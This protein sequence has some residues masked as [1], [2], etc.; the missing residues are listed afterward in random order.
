VS[1]KK[2]PRSAKSTHAKQPKR[3][4]LDARLTIVQAADLHRALSARLA[5]GR[6][7]V[8]DGTRVEEIDTAILQLLTSLW[9]TSQERGI[10]C[11]WHGAS[12]ALR[13]T[14]S[15]IGADDDLRSPPTE[16]KS[17]AVEQCR[18]WLNWAAAH[19]DACLSSD[20][21]ASDQLLASLADWLKETQPRPQT[22]PA[23]ANDTAGGK[24]SAV[25]IAIQSHDSVMQRLTHVAQ[26]LRALH[27]QLGDAQRAD[28]TESWRMLR[29][30]QFRAFSM[31]EERALFARLV[32]RGDE[33]RHEVALDPEETVELFT[34]NDGLHEP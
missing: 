31:A 16:S 1:K 23:P 11:T 24:M 5:E 20:N 10:A 18:T 19:V 29:E 8:V 26:S 21:L 2:L 32:A 3:V 30:R 15:L 13:Q 27:E 28:S 6:H 14:A 4:E 25:V 22:A 9:R 7:I 12:D 34:I 33:S 17:V